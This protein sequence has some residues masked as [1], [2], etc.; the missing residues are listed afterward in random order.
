MHRVKMEI[1][2]PVNLD[3]ERRKKYEKQRKKQGFSDYDAY[4]TDDYIL[5]LIPNMIDR[6]CEFKHSYGLV[7]WMYDTGEEK[8]NLTPEE[9]FA[10]LKYVAN[11][12]RK[13]AKEPWAWDDEMILKRNETIERCFQWL[14][15]NLNTLWD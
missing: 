14:G 3:K 7:L 6:L 15:K 11:K 10:E 2:L 12:M 8:H 1:P 13:Y 4:N 9:Y 5:T